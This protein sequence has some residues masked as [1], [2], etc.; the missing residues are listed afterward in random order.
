M[1]PGRLIFWIVVIAG[2]LWLFQNR[3]KL[4]GNLRRADER[5]STPAA[6]QDSPLSEAAREADKASPGGITENM[7]PGQVRSVLG[8]PDS[9]EPV[10]TDSGKPRERWIYRQAG[11]AVVFENGVAI[12]VE[13]P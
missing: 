13:A 9:I 2:A 4:L 8:N 12:S 7:T 1:K 5:A 10:T 6:A 11:K 3:A